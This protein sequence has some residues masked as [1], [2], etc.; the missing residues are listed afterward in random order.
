MRFEVGAFCV[1]FLAAAVR[2]LVYSSP[3]VGTHLG[4]RPLPWNLGRPVEKGLGRVGPALGHHPM[5]PVGS[6]GHDQSLVLVHELGRGD[7][8]QGHGL[9]AAGLG[10]QLEGKGVVGF[11]PDG[12]ERGVGDVG[13]P[14]HG[15]GGG[16]EAVHAGRVGE[17]VVEVQHLHGPDPL[18]RLVLI[19]TLVVLLLV[20]LFFFPVLKLVFGDVCVWIQ[21]GLGDLGV[22]LGAHRRGAILGGDGGH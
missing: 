17:A 7:G 6:G 8:P 2:A 13:I 19:L 3:A 5:S 12:R 9:R 16:G 18:L 22:R 4:P 14:G 20:L 15:G 11:G 21:L 10:D 1:D